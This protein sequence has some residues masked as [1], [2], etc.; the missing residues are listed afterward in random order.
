MT[1]TIC[2]LEF[3]MHFW[4]LRLLW[5]VGVYCCFDT[6]S[7]YQDWIVVCASLLDIYFS[8]IASCGGHSAKAFCINY[9]HCSL[10][11]LD[12]I[13][14][15][16][17]STQMV[18][19]NTFFPHTVSALIWPCPLLF[20]QVHCSAQMSSLEPSSHLLPLPISFVA[21]HSAEARHWLLSNL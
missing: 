15:P 8:V 11:I 4:Y 3:Q 10:Y 2:S 6:F 14:Y 5:T 18:K 7:N 13:C 12:F 9:I 1:S 17:W 21:F 19:G 20:I 16:F